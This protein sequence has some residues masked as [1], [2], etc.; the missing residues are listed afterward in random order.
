M[1]TKATWGIDRQSAEW[2]GAAANQ[3]TLEEAVDQ[4]YKWDMTGGSLSH[5]L[6]ADT[7]EYIIDN[8]MAEATEKYP[9]LLL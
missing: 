4:Y 6:Q 8:Y 3:P 5:M 2:Q 9:E 1:N 7:L